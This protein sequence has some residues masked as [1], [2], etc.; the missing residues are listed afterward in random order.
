MGEFVSFFPL[1]GSEVLEKSILSLRRAE[2]YVFIRL[3]F[4]PLNCFTVLTQYVTLLD[5]IHPL[6]IVVSFPNINM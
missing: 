3:K 6:Q 2:S 5:E 1:G 4:F